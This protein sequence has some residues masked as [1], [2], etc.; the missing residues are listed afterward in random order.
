MYIKDD[1]IYLEGEFIKNKKITGTTFVSLC[2]KDRFNK[3]GDTILQM[4]G[5]YKNKVDPKY[6]KRGDCAEWLVKKTYIKYG[7]HPVTYDKKEIGYDN[8]HDNAVL[9]G[10]IDIE[11]PEEKS[12]IEVKSKSMSKYNEYLTY[13]DEKE[14]FQGELYAYLRNY[15][16]FYMEWIFFDK[17]TEDEVFAGE[18]PKTYNNLKRI[19]RCYSVDRTTMDKLITQAVNYRDRCYNDRK[20]PLV[21]ITPKVILYL[22]ENNLLKN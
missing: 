17:P 2:G 11:L 12:L 9:G 4:M 3:K 8:F 13:E 15:N 22:R 1:Y 5:L 10:M 18:R 21:D 6:L 7:H 19:S 14:I 16:K 20:I